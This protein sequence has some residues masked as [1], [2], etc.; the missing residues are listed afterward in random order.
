MIRR[1]ISACAAI[2]LFVC[3]VG[4]DVGFE[5]VDTAGDIAFFLIIAAAALPMS[6]DDE[7][8]RREDERDRDPSTAA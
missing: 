4:H 8:G 2:A 5:G 7:R 1:F 3:I 6:R